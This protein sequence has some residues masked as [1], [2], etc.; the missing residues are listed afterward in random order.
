MVGCDSLDF[1]LFVIIDYYWLLLNEK[2][3]NF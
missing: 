1:V 3:K 2:R